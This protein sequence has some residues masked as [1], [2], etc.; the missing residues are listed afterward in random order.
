MPRSKTNN[1]MT[2][3][4]LVPFSDKQEEGT[5]ALT[6]KE[7]WQA[8][9]EVVKF[10]ALA[11]AARDKLVKGATESLRKKKLIG[12][13]EDPI[14]STNFNRPALGMREEDG[15]MVPATKKKGRAGK[16]APSAAVAKATKSL[17]L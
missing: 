8:A 13:D 2:G 1:L 3:V 6:T 7:L 5:I 9:Q 15:R 14:I 4:V 10:N 12:E 11:A 17:S 16:A